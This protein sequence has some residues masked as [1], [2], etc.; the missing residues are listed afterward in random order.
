MKVLVITG[1]K[2]F[3]PG[4]PRFD[5]QKS[6][7]ER[8]E[9]LY[10]GRGSLW[11]TLPQGPFDVVTAQ[12]PLWRGLFGWYASKRLGAKLNV[13]IHMDL[14]SLGG[15]RHVLAQV[16]VRHA[17]SIR[18]VSQ[19]IK[20]QVGKFG[21]NVPVHVLPVFVELD[22]LRSVVHER[23]EGKV[24]LWVGRF[25]REKNPLLAVEV[26]KKVK[27]Q[28]IDARLSM[29]G[30]GSLEPQL[31][32]CVSRLNLEKE[33]EFP[34]WQSPTVFLAKADV[35]LCTSLYESWGQS[36]VEALAAGVPVVAPDV[37]VAREAGAIVVERSQLAEA[38]VQVLTLGT[39]GQLQLT[40]P[41]REQWLDQWQKSLN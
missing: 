16:V 5:V 35:V 26:L 27:A 10:W 20:D 37:G 18:V 3:G 31:R 15:L 30:A 19:K 12:D 34:G 9:V 21:V 2:R 41:S 23:H 22:A 32:A 28:G 7:V 17:D 29:L 4:H 6:A 8:L 24:V 11:P 25:E 40:M 13:Q 39:P 33:V 1:D 36:M 14:E 38:V